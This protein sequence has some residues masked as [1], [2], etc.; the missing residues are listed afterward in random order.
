LPRAAA[1]EP[2]E[3][4]YTAF[5][6]AFAERNDPRTVFEQLLTKLPTWYGLIVLL[7][8]ASIL[9]RQRPRPRTL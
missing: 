1:S 8:A 3:R 5:M 4:S 9:A 2:A 6:D 7:S